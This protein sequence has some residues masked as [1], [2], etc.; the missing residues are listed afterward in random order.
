VKK[1]SSKKKLN[2][3][4]QNTK[5]DKNILATSD[6]NPAN[7]EDVIIDNYQFTSERIPISVTVVKKGGEFVPTYN[8]QIS[9]ISKTTEMILEKVRLELIRRVSLGVEDIGDIK[10]TDLVEDKFNQLID[11][12]ID[13]YFPDSN[14]ETVN[15]LRSYLKINSLGLGNLELLMND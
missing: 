5:H 9:V 3:K 1:H 4:L 8:L 14:Q 12:L 10:K 7:K 6:S 2:S 13:K 15:F 11:V